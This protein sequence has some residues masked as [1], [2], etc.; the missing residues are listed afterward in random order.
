MNKFLVSFSLLFFST[1]L[2]KCSY[3]YDEV[4]VEEEQMGTW[5]GNYIYKG[6]IKCKT[7][8]EDESVLIEQLV[9][10]NSVYDIDC[11]NDYFYKDDH[12]YMLL[13][14]KEYEEHEESLVLKIK[15]SF[16]IDYSIENK[17]Y[18][19]L[20]SMSDEVAT[21]LNFYTFEEKD[22]AFIRVD[23]SF[24][25]L[26]KLDLNSNQVDCSSD[27]L[28]DLYNYVF[29]NDD[30]LIVYKDNMIKYTYCDDI[31][32]IDIKQV[33]Y[34]NTHSL[35]YSLIDNNYLSIKNYDSQY[36]DSLSSLV[37]YKSL[38][39]YDLNKNKLSSVFKTTDQMELKYIN[40][41]YFIKG[42]TTSYEYVSSLRNLK[43]HK[44]EVLMTTLFT[45]NSLYKIDYETA[46]YNKIYDFKDQDIDFSNGYI[47]NEKYYIN[48]EYI[49]KGWALNPGGYK[50]K[51]YILD[52]KNL[53]LRKRKFE[54]Q[55]QESRTESNK[56]INYG[57]YEYYLTS[58]HIGPIMGGDYAYFLNRKNTHTEK[59][60][61]IQF[62]AFDNDKL[63]GTRYSSLL[64]KD[65]TEHFDDKNIYITNK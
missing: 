10:E 35:S 19:V 63:I 28:L 60:E 49:K 37:S 36:V 33:E 26:I 46:T 50:H 12:I 1:S 25:S 24:S 58:K 31:N 6:N 34:A 44:Y 61:V 42:S 15:H 59:V 54:K 56:I 14:S 62:F 55:K 39:I 8:G 3:S 5:D 23:K 4:K 45:H 40:D 47:L 9:I 21:M 51:Q 65:D 11:V 30:I 38:D 13:E 16:L 43:T 2:V 27:A 32:L 20:Y 53:K 22:Y 57:G 18:E 17:S 52:L 7:T 48:A 64:W 41:Y 29:I